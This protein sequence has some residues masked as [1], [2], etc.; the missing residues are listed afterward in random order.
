M[1]ALHDLADRAVAAGGHDEGLAAAHGVGGKGGRVARRF[2]EDERG[3]EAGNLETAVQ[4]R[5]VPAETAAG[6]GRVH[7]QDHRESIRDAIPRA[8]LRARPARDGL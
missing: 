3:V 5:P 7:D 4:A 2:G 8:D 1:E 6:G